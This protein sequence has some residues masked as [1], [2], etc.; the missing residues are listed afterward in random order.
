MTDTKVHFV[1]NQD[2]T[3]CGAIASI[4]NRAV[5]WSNVTCLR[6]LGRPEEADVRDAF[7]SALDMLDKILNSD[8]DTYTQT[9]A[10]RREVVNAR[11]SAMALVRSRISDDV[12]AAREATRIATVS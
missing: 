8:L 12:K 1:T 11:N 6:C 10:I 3:A 2:V 5:Q 4:P 9:A 7:D